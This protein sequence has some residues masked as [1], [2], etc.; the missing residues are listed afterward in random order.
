[1]DKFIVKI[2]DLIITKRERILSEKLGYIYADKVD[3]QEIKLYRY[4]LDDIDG[5]KERN[6][7][8][9]TYRYYRS[10]V[11]DMRDFI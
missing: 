1:M 2:L 8:L 10:K 11:W 3:N 7:G 5:Y 9:T 6:W 4:I